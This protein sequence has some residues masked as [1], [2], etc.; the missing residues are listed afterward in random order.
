LIEF[1]IWPPAAT[2]KDVVSRNME[3]RYFARCGRDREVT[4][5]QRVD[6]VRFRA[7]GFSPVHVIESCCVD[8]EAGP[9][10]AERVAYLIKLRNIERVVAERRYFMPPAGRHKALA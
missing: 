10:G 7:T 5:A 2:A 8:Y 4:W 1:V 3:Q 6:G 9:I